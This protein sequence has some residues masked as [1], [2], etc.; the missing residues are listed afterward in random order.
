MTKK[1]LMFYKLVDFI[2]DKKSESVA[3][4]S[5]LRITGKTT[6]LLQLKEKY[7]NRAIYVDTSKNVDVVDLVSDAF[8]DES[9]KLILIDEISYLND[10]ETLCQMFFNQ[11]HKPGDVVKVV[12]TGSSP[13]HITMLSSSKLGARASLFRLPLLTFVE[14]LYFTGKI[15]NYYDYSNAINDDFA[16]YLRMDGMEFSEAAELAITFTE[17]YFRAFYDEVEEG[18]RASRL[19]TSLIHLKENDLSNFINILAYKLSEPVTYARTVDP[20]IGGQEHIHL[21]GQKIKVKKSAVDLSD[22]IVQES[23]VAVGDMSISDIGRILHFLIKSGLAAL[24]Y[25][26]TSL[27]DSPASPSDILTALI[28]A[29]KKADLTNVFEKVSICMVSPL[30]YTRIGE[31][32]L[33]LKGVDI[34]HLYKG[35]LYGKMLEMYVRGAVC[36]LQNKTILSTQ[37]L[38]F[39]Q[40]AGE[41]GG[42]MIRLGEVD[43]WDKSLQLLCEITV[44][45]KASSKVNISKY[46]LEAPLIR[47]CT[48]A[49]KDFF[50]NKNKHHWI[51]YAKFC[52]MLD[53]GDISSLQPCDGMK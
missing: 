50:D 22:S 13:S 52:C 11:T 24:E 51:P 4:L 34:S 12:I 53:V 27:D 7:G 47:V 18:N 39:Y 44:S 33:Q 25:N 10:Y 3:L 40:K 26:R 28:N 20:D 32:I 49:N 41:G 30:F 5:G 15:N 29:S 21:I 36:M 2:E 1:R 17:N 8:C 43:I 23:A 6:L 42:D 45:D 48:S 14:Y 38:D 35:M 9:I 37:K 31:E 16:K 19:T 46:F